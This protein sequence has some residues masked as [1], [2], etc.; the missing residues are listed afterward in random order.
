MSRQWTT[1]ALAAL[2]AMAVTMPAV[3]APAGEHPSVKRPFNLPPSMDLSYH[4]DAKQRGFGLSGDAVVSWRLKGDSYTLTESTRASILGKILE[5]KSEGTI[6]SYGI[7]PH[8]FFE[9]RFRKDPATTT[10]DRETKT[11]TFTE[12]DERYPIK[13]GEQDRS[14][15]SWQLLAVARAAPEKFTPGSE[16]TFFVAGRHDAEQWTF[17]VIN[18]E[19]VKTATGDVLAV[20]LAKAPPPDSKDQTVDIWLAPSLDWAPVRVRFTDANGDFV[21]QVLTKLTKK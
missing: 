11:I 8:T 19:S 13:G 17:K 3:A 5:H 2:V 10:F 21:D 16:W 20:H 1:A 4:I 6:D 7:A 15:A 18:Q 12:G 9:K 14:T